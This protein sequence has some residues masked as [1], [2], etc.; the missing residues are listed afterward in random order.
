MARKKKFLAWF[1]E[2]NQLKRPDTYQILQLLFHEEQLLRISHFV[3]DVRYLPNALIIS[4]EGAPTVS[5]LCRI[6]GIY[7]ENVAEVTAVLINNPPEELYIRLAFDRELICCPCIE[8]LAEEPDVEF[9]ERLKKLES[10]LNRI[11]FLKEEKRLKLQAEI[12]DALE[13]RD[14]DRF[15]YLSDLYKKFFG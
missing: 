5:F 13:K 1:M 4:A 9:S 11:A 15:Y 2:K 14:R 12:D 8:Q 10:E 6:N 3:D 7:Y